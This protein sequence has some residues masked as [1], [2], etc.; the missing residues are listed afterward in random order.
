VVDHFAFFGRQVRYP[1]EMG[2]PARLNLAQFLYQFPLGVFA[3]ALA[4]AIFPSLSSDALDKDRDKFRSALRGG[5]EATLWEGIPASLGLILV[6]GPA[7]RLLFQHGQITA[8]DADLIG[9]SVLYYS[10][11]IWAFSLLQIV[12]RAY[13]AIHDTVTPLVM[14]VVNIVLNLVVEIPLLWWLGESAMAVGTLV[15]FA[16]QA[17]VM[18]LMLDRKIGGLDLRRSAAPVMKMIV[19]AVAMGLACWGL[20]KLPMYPNGHTRI[21]W[22]IQSGLLMT[23]GAGVYVGVCTV[24]GIGV[25]EQIM[26]LKTARRKKASNT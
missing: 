26:P 21:S 12:N 17:V 18:L 3:I 11:A 14:S 16:I 1:M 23:V 15:S 19:A 24:M 8:H 4:T 13:Y 20:E 10:G 7:V 22:L 5:I 9:Q 6:R 25:M 2:A